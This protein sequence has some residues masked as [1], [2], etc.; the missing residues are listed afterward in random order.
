MNLIPHFIRRKIESRP[1]LL[2]IIDNIGWLFLDKIVRMGVGL[3]VGVWV[4]RYLG[5]EQF[6]LLSFAIAFV[7]LFG[8]FV[9][10]GLPSIVVRDIVRDPSRKETTLGTAAALQL[11][12]GFLSYALLMFFIFW[13]RADDP[14]AMAIVAILGSM[15]LFKAADVAIYWFESQVQSKY[16]VVVQNGVFIF[17]ALSKIV[18]ILIGSSVFAFA[19][20]ALGEAMVAAILMAFLMGRYGEALNTLEVRWTRAK[21]LLRDSWPL[22][23]SSV[24]VTIYMKIDQIMLASMKGDEAAGI[25][26]AALRISEIWYFFPVAICASIFPSMLEMREHDKGEYYKRLQYLFDIMVWISIVLALFTTLFS[27]WVVTFLFG[28]EYVAAGPVLAIHIWGAVFVFLGVASSQ[29]FI[30]ENLQFLSLQRTLIGLI[31]NVFGNIALIPT[32]GALGAAISTIVSQAIAAWGSDILQSRTR[33]LFMM[34][35]RSFSPFAIFNIVRGKPWKGSEKN[36]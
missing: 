9:V 12:S 36:D 13:L 16:I 3:F 22:L 21:E 31:I 15:V 20:V 14:L 1:V 2:R 8:A 25:Y 19:W 30:A 34:K 27:T 29:W 17:F 5:P 28:H 23:L 6:G 32:Y 18:L 35:T 7:S 10:L 11:A 33:A 4:A 24:A 26:S